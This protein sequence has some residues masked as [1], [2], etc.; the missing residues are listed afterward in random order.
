ARSDGETRQGRSR[1]WASYQSRTAL[2]SM[3][4]GLASMGWGYRVWDWGS[5]GEEPPPGLPLMRGRGW[6]GAF[7][8]LGLLVTRGGVTPSLWPRTS[9]PNLSDATEHFRS[10]TC[11]PGRWILCC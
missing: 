5:K 7:L 10:P 11:W 1:A 4:W 3:G 8:L 9:Y 2:A 6:I